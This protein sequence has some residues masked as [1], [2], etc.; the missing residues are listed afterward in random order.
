M[1]NGP[2]FPSAVSSTYGEAPFGTAIRAY[3]RPPHRASWS[4]SSMPMATPDIR[5]AI[6]ASE[7]EAVLMVAMGP[8]RIGIVNCAGP[9]GRVSIG[10]HGDSPNRCEAHG[11]DM[12]VSTDDEVGGVAA[13]LVSLFANSLRQR[14]ASRLCSLPAH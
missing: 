3:G 4:W 8:V 11:R 7:S 12:G 2:V 10:S 6:A 14:K 5:M 1:R 13:D 9:V